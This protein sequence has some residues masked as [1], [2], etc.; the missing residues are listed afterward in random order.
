[1]LVLLFL[2]THI[3][4]AVRTNGMNIYLSLSLSGE[5]QTQNY[6][7]TSKTALAH[8]SQY[9]KQNMWSSNRTLVDVYYI[10]VRFL[11]EVMWSLNSANC[12]LLGTVFISKLKLGQYSETL[13]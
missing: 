2:V 4:N 8:N 11:I 10:L 7:E 3:T 12:G 5:V 13:Q 9:H 6:K 1:M